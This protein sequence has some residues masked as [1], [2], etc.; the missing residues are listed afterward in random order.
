MRLNY[1][2]NERAFRERIRRAEYD[3]APTSSGDSD[4]G[5]CPVARSLAAQNEASTELAS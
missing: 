1:A 4:E 2:C 3:G 5:Q